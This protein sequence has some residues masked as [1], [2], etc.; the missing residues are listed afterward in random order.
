MSNVS[1]IGYA[2]IMDPSKSDSLGSDPD[3]VWI[4]GHQRFFGLPDP[5]LIGRSLEEVLDSQGI[6]H[7][8]FLDTLGATTVVEDPNRRFNAVLY[9]NVPEEV[10]EKIDADESEARLYPIEVDP[11]KVADFVDDSQWRHDGN[12]IFMYVAMRVVRMERVGL[13]RLTQKTIKPNPD[14]LQRCRDAAQVQ[15]AD[16]LREY[17]ETTFLAD[18]STSLAE[19]DF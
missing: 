1:I 9:R 2:T 5:S 10:K 12:C 18:R 13:I 8:E 11:L 15:G 7:P 14:Y 17:N 6:V 3:Q 19:S 16:F 4:K